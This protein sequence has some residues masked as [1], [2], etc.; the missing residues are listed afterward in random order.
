MSEEQYRYRQERIQAEK[1][2]QKQQKRGKS[3]KKFSIIK[4]VFLAFFI[5]GILAIGIG[6]IVFISMIKDAPKL[7]ASK[8]E[9]PLSTKFYDKNGNFL[10]EYGKEKRTNIT[11][12]QLPEMLEHAF[13]A[14][15]DARFYKHHGIDM[16]G[17]ARAITENLTG[18]FGS[19][20]GSTITQQV[21]KNS[22]LSPEKTI[23]RKV[24]EWS[25]A[26][27]LE[28][29]YTKH[30]ILMMYL[31]KIYLGNRSYGVAAAAK[32]YYG[33]DSNH[34][35]QLTLPEMAMLAGLP[36]SP[37]HYDP[38]VPENREAATNRRNVVLQAMYN[39]GYITKKQMKDAEKVPVTKGL[40]PKNK[41]QGMPNEAFLDAAVKEVES[42]LKNV[43]ISTDG[44]SI[45]T[46]IDPKAQ[47]YA[48]KILNT[49]SI[50]AYP[51]AKFQGAFVFLD[52]KTGEVRAIGSGRKDFKASFRGNN[53]AIDIKRQP[54]SS[55]KPILDYGPAIENLKWSTAHQINDQ[56]TTYYSGQSISNWDN[57]YHGMLSIRKALQWSYNIPALL[58][59]REV[60]LD[61]A[62]DFA[63]NLGIH[64]ENNTV[65]ESYA[66]G[67]NT[68]SPL[69]MAGAYSA[70]GN[71][72]VY[73][74][75]HFVQKVV[76]PNG[77]VVHF[78]PKPKQVMHDYTAYLITD[79]LRTVVRSGTGTT[80]NVPGLDIAGKTGTTNF[81]DKTIA[82]YGYPSQAT[83]DSWMVGYTP[84]YTMAVWT[85][86]E[87]NGPGNFMLGD[88]TKISQLL[89]KNMM[90]AFGTDHS[91]FQQPSDVYRM[92]NELYIKGGNPQDIPRPPKKETHKDKKPKPHGPKH[93]H[94][95]HKDKPKH[96]PKKKPGKGKHKHGG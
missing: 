76:Y 19:Q 89:F 15:E 75:P 67:S 1:A 72:G 13:I 51:N 46:T 59:L 30:Q 18:N 49:N 6:T 17:T 93:D 65:Y 22:F 70:F 20:G 54:G 79:M 83:N 24:Q 73:N 33:V 44:L 3:S 14:T 2:K 71:K 12:S 43:D 36:Q 80:A 42:K 34:L 35:K 82:R 86:Y 84:Q 58:T 7:D 45:Y 5:L 21:I 26:Y 81:D 41:K 53:F 94:P 60:G 57:Q 87:K 91:P 9:V 29:K 61:K 23:K 95:K 40:V 88:T 63:K 47:D 85:G 39:Q 96:G 25:L 10:Y 52:T 4:K 31:N 37:S 16:K 74:A 64:F 11:Y 69:E 32:S 62:R 8:L 48:D 66:I 78:T 56:P 38:T 55:F 90:N 50:V 27:Q 28:N 68:V 92:Y 77:K